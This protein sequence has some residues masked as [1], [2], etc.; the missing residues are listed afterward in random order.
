ME[1]AA[2]KPSLHRLQAK[3]HRQIVAIGRDFR[4]SLWPAAL[5]VLLRPG[6]ARL[7]GLSDLLECG[8]VFGPIWLKRRWATALPKFTITSLL[9]RASWS[10][11][12]SLA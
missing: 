9:L 10:S 3:P 6:A 7:Q 4:D 1:A 5:E 2:A 11:L 8:G 12:M